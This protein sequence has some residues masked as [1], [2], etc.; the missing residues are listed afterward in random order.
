IVQ[1]GNGTGAGV[2]GGRRPAWS[3]CCREE[4]KRRAGS[5]ESLPARWRSSMKIRILLATL[6]LCVPTVARAQVAEDALV[7]FKDGF[8][9]TGKVRQQRTFDVEDK[10]RISVPHGFLYIDDQIRRIVFTPTAS[11]VIDVKKTDPIDKDHVIL[12]K[13][14][15]SARADKIL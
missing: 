10:V 12:T 6:G 3:H 15:S 2:L 7:I 14:H 8:T 4:A 11:Q 5:A 1:G 13:P 9:V